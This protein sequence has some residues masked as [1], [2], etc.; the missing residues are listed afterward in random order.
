MKTLSYDT[1]GG[2]QDVECP[3]SLAEMTP[4]QWLEAVRYML[5]NE[6]S[7][8]FFTT[9]AGI[10]ADI[11][12]LL[13][14]FQKFSIEDYFSF[15][16]YP[17]RE[18]LTFRDWKVPEIA[19]GD[20]HYYGPISN[21]GN[22]TWGEFVYADQCMMNGMHQALVAALFR[23]ERKD[24]DGETDRRLPFTIP[25]TVHRYEKFSELDPVTL[26]AVLLNYMAMRRASLEETYPEIFP[27]SGGG[28]E[29]E[30]D[31][32]DN[33]KGKENSGGFS[34]TGVHRNLLGDNIHEEEKYLH[35]NVHT[36]LH[37]LNKLIIDNKRRH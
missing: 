12:P 10:P 1:G 24:Y 13:S 29:N 28:G 14:N 2:R 15:I 36:V 37:R 8:S 27:E 11:V 21:F 5:Q 7:E 9:I 34:W 26:N 33:E 25:G 16:L 31:D 23:P 4:A 19:I 32:D 20:V 17:K 18:D 22:I 6:P 3:E 35:L 30:D